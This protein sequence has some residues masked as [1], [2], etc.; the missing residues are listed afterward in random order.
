MEE[1]IF[2]NF[3]LTKEK[4]EETISNFIENNSNEVGID[5]SKIY[6][7]DLAYCPNYTGINLQQ[8]FG[9]NCPINMTNDYNKLTI[10]FILK[11]QSK[12][13][14]VFIDIFN[15]SILQSTYV[16]V[17]GWLSLMQETRKGTTV[18]QYISLKDILDIDRLCYE[19]LE[20]IFDF[21]SEVNKNEI[22]KLIVD[23]SLSI[24]F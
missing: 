8:N 16:N 23:F 18:Y 7:A 4:L 22:I 9:I 17:A 15:K 21:I 11:S 2:E 3:D 6:L 19:K 20:S 5:L 24:I 10:V 1:K 13:D 12:D 14:H